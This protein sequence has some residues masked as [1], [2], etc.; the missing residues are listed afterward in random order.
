MYNF[1]LFVY[2]RMTGSEDFSLKII[3]EKKGCSSDNKI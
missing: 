1:C 2:C 3:H